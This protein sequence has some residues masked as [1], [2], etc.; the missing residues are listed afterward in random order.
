MAKKELAPFVLENVKGLDSC[1]KK[2]SGAYGAVYEVTVKGVTCIAKRLHDIL[3]TE[4]SPS[5]KSSIQQKFTAECVL[6]SKLRHPNVVHFVGVH[7]GRS[8]DDLSLVMECLHTDLAKFLKGCSNE[9]SL[10]I[11][12]SILLDVSYGLLYFHTHTPPIIHRDLSANNVLLTTDL[13]AKIADLGVAKLLDIQT[14]VAI[15]QTKAPG[16]LHY[17]PPEALEEVPDYNLKLDIFSFGH[18]TLYVAAQNPPS[19]H[20]LDER[21]TYTALKTHTIQIRRRR[22]AIDEI[23]GERHTLYPLIT[24]CLQDKH[25]SR[26]TTTVLNNS[27]KELC[28]KHPRSVA[29]LSLTADKVLYLS[30]SA[31]SLSQ[32][33]FALQFAFNVMHG[34]GS[35]YKLKNENRPGKKEQLYTKHSTN[36]SFELKA[37]TYLGQSKSN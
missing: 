25:E 12:L 37:N 4:V 34:R 20:E 24:Q 7:Y 10:S 19:V 30:V 16:S 22:R 32:A 21:T 11:K 29:E 2:G 31:W 1:E 9:I 18:L 33:I 17:M 27:L 26:P 8:V 23:G 5:E 35:K 36:Y 13:R 3:V 15:S 14:Q 28:T 6:L